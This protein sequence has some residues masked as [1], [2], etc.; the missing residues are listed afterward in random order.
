MPR[1]KSKLTPEE[2]AP[3]QL[4]VPD[5]VQKLI[6]L[7]D[8]NKVEYPWTE[9]DRGEQRFE[10]WKSQRSSTYRYVITRIDR[11]RNYKRTEEYYFYQMK[12]YVQNDNDVEEES[13]EL[14]YGFAVEKKHE[15]K[16]S[17]RINAKEPIFKRD[18]PTYFFK[19]D[20]DQVRKLLEGSDE[21]CRNF[22]LGDMGDKGQ[23]E[24][25]SSKNIVQLGH[26]SAQNDFI[27]GDFDDLVVLARAPPTGSESGLGL[28]KRL[29]EEQEQQVIARMRENLQKKK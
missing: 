10:Y 16:Y 25:S 7:Y 22:C 2:R 19:W 15:L 9:E 4:I 14:T 29:K 1:Y 5:R 13:R 3:Q 17:P 21:P 23:G 11:V 24:S 27:E 20:K 6:D 28:V 8:K 12:Q 26:P 18:I